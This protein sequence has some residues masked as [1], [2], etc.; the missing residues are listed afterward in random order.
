MIGNVHVKL[1]GKVAKLLAKIDPKAYDNF[2]HMENGKKVLYV[3]LRKALY[4]TLQAA[5]LFWQT[6][7]EKLLKWGFEF[8]PY[9]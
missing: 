3:K 9:D 1:E 7:S 5:L 8:N 2:I 6:L 4:G